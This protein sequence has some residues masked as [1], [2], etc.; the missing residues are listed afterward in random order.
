MAG[1]RRGLLGKSRVGTFEGPASVAHKFFVPGSADKET[2]L[3]N[4][5]GGDGDNS[6]PAAIGVPGETAVLVPVN[7]AGFVV[8]I[9][10]GG[11]RRTSRLRHRNLRVINYKM[12]TAPT[13][14]LNR[15]VRVPDL[16]QWCLVC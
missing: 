16:R 15:S 13:A 12:A 7:A 4:V 10:V 5:E 9:V 14:L 8:G 2:V 6:S 1:A 11:F 3:G